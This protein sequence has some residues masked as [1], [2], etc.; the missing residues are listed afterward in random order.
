VKA[1]VDAYDGT[2]TFYVVDD[3]DPL[4]RAYQDAFPDLFTDGDDAP[5]ELREHFRYPEDL[6]GVQTNM[7]TRYHVTEALRFYQ[8]NDNWLLSPDPGSGRISNVEA[9]A[10]QAT[11][12][13]TP[14]DQPQDATSTSA[15]ME[16]YYLNLQ[17]PGESEADFLILQPFVPVSSGNSVTRLSSFMVARSDPD[18]YGEM[19]A[20]SMPEGVQVSGPVQVNNEINSEPEIAER[21]ALLTRGGSSVIQGSMQLIPVGDSI[22][23]VRPYYVQSSGQSSFPTFRYVAVFTEG[24]EPVLA[25]TVPE[26][27][28]SLITG[29]PPPLDGEEPTEPDGETPTDA[30][31]DELLADA[32]AKFDEAQVALEAGDLGEYQ[33]LVEEAGQLIQQARD[34]LAGESPEPSTTTTST[35]PPQET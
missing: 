21:L 26:A 7:Y 19:T 30:T 20:F 17:L 3:E 33:D 1:T 12:G 22:I 29:E 6:F 14:T 15:R 16:P 31:V 35:S 27:L 4:I 18:S 9:L 13:T 5:E 32:A 23:Y 34:I 24:E 8:G 2:I 11:S 28:A 25:E 10:E